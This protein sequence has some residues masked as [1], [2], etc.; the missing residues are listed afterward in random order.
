[1]DFTEK[2]LNDYNDYMDFIREEISIECKTKFT[3]SGYDPTPD[4][5][6]IKHISKEGNDDRWSI[7]YSVYYPHPVMNLIKKIPEKKNKVHGMSKKVNYHQ[8]KAIK[9]ANERD[10]KLKQLGI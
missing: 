5:I 1:M 3:N 4:E 2:E 6:E 10:E 9:I 8:W 7:T